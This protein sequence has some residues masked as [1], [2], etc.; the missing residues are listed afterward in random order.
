[1]KQTLTRLIA[2][3][4]LSSCFAGTTLATLAPPFDTEPFDS[5][6]AGNSAA[7][8]LGFFRRDAGPEQFRYFIGTNPTADGL[9]RL[10]L[11]F[12]A[13]FT[14][15]P[16]NDFAILTNSQSWGAQADEA[17]FEFFLNDDLQGFFT[18][19]LTPD[20]LLEF[21]LPGEGLVANRIV[22]S[23]VTPDPPGVNDLATMT[24]DDAGIA[25]LA[26]PPAVPAVSGLG[27]L[28]LVAITL[29]VA[30]FALRSKS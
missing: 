6:S 8:T 21:D 30:S 11:D 5:D 15:G 25:Y 29:L 28:V 9:G 10:I 16:G 14:D 3:L 20:E 27:A 26:G 4:I 18:V 7:N 19:S 22:I 1:M 12:E 13:R 24:F 17:L 2:T 23:N